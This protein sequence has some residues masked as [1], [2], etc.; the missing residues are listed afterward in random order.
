[1][2]SFKLAVNSLK[3][4][5][6]SIS[7]LRFVSITI[8]AAVIWLPGGREVLLAAIYRISSSRSRWCSNLHSP[9]PIPTSILER[10]SGNIEEKLGLISDKQKDTC[11]NSPH[12]ILHTALQHS[13][14]YHDNQFASSLRCAGKWQRRACSPP[15][16]DHPIS[17]SC[18]PKQVKSKKLITTTMSLLPLRPRDQLT[19]T[20][21]NPVFHVSP[22]QFSAS[23]SPE[24]PKHL[25]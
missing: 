15:I 5:S 2:C 18:H 25:E 1:M 16:P 22:S 24:V 8:Q 11:Y 10:T 7:I 9:S 3:W 12:S 14:L 6:S 17:F 19:A 4:A 20:N 13:G 21:H 23:S